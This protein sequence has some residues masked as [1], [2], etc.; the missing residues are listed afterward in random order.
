ML[1]RLKNIPHAILVV[2]EYELTPFIEKL[3][4]SKKKQH[5]DVHHCHLEGKSGMH[6]MESLRRLQ[7]Q[8]ALVPLEAPKKIFVIHD[9]ER[10]LPTSANALLKT[11]EEPPEK[12]VIILTSSSENSLLPTIRSRCQIFRYPRAAKQEDPLA[13]KLHEAVLG[14]RAVIKEIEQ[15]LERERKVWEK[16][17][18]GALPK[19]MTMK[20]KEGMIK[21]VEGA[22]S[23]RYQTRVRALFGELLT[24]QRDELAKRVGSA[25]ILSQKEVPFR[26]LSTLVER[27]SKAS[28]AI[29]RGMKF[30]HALEY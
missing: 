30:S 15:T 24:W 18:L 21:E 9:A 1:E 20:Q 19:E 23:L 13:S 10:M 25:H 11:L 17:L 22:L 28:I 6:S 8:A 29:S 16:E 14:N 3:V 2:G 5:P 4:E 27:V 12:T 26:P 7:E